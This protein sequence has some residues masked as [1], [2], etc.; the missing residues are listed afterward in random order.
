MRPARFRQQPATTP[1]ALEG[2]VDA[3]HHFSLGRS[4]AFQDMIA[5]SH[6]NLGGVTRFKVR[7]EACQCH[8]LFIGREQLLGERFPV[9]FGRCAIPEDRLVTDLAHPPVDQIEQ[10]DLRA[11]PTAE[12]QGAEKRL[13][14]PWVTPIDADDLAGAI[15]GSRSRPV[16]RGD[17][18][19]GER[20]REQTAAFATGG[21]A[22]LTL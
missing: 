10:D 21:G 17:Q 7:N 19:C 14:G 3:G 4:E 6:S 8:T 9:W 20:R 16:A 18:I 1:V 15:R 5:A 11:C 12:K 22:E 2:D 13:V